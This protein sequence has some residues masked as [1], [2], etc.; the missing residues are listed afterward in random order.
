MDE[1]NGRLAK[2]APWL[3]SHQDLPR[4]N[5]HKPLLS[6]TYPHTEYRLSTCIYV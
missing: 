5:L 3:D 2:N 1:R 6:T 4:V